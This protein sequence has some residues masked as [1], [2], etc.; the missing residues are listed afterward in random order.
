MQS[1]FDLAINLL[2]VDG[3]YE[4]VKNLTSVALDDVS[5]LIFFQR[6]NEFMKDEIAEF[7]TNLLSRV[8]A[9]VGVIATLLMTIW[10]LGK[11]FLIVTGQSRES[12]MGLVMSSA[13]AM[14][15]LFFATT[16]SVASSD[17]SGLINDDIPKT[18][19]YAVSGNT[20]DVFADID[21]S[22]GYM[23]AA[24][25][26]IDAIQDGGDATV[27]GQ[28]D[29]AMWF[30]GIG[31]GGPAITAGVMMLLNRIAMA[32]FIGLGP[33]FIL[34]LLFN[35]TKQLFSRWLFYGL[36]TMFSLA[37]LSVMVTLA[38]DA[39]LAVAASFWV[40]SII[41]GGSAEGVNSMAMQQGGLGLLLTMLMISAPAMAANFFQGTLGQFAAYSSFG[42]FG[43]A[44]SSASSAPGTRGTGSPPTT[45]APQNTQGQGVGDTRSAAL[46]PT[47]SGRLYSGTTTA[48]STH[49]APR[50]A[51]EATHAIN[52]ETQSLTGAGAPQ[53]LVNNAAP[54]VNPTAVQ[55][56]PNVGNPPPRGGSTS[57]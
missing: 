43:G 55:S 22:L 30:A 28:K 39:I 53:Q 11:G 34:C 49:D 38:L 31:T 26:S 35:G 7:G 20:G 12:M 29:R 52:R 21:Q 3:M 36:A 23:Q 2:G 1:T 45:A 56:P 24:F 27:S 33:I 14:L 25:S 16:W 9:L 48:A 15:I 51:H 47:Q 32:L 10:I 13:K 40:G 19:Y 17:I 5:K 41:S 42:T 44:S 54:K 37:V 6:I 46:T 18:I 4:T 8:G 57:S 50:A